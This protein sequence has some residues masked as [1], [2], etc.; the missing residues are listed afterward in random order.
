MEVSLHTT[1]ETI[2]L[3]HINLS[4][5]STCQN[6]LCSA[7]DATKAE[8]AVVRRLS[9]YIYICISICIA[10]VYIYIYIYIIVT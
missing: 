1:N 6:A 7:D 3:A 2:F 5:G 8:T 4:V 10:A 9:I